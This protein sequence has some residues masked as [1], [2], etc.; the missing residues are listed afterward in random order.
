[1]RVNPLRF[2]AQCPDTWAR[3]HSAKLPDS[4]IFAGLE[5]LHSV[6]KHGAESV[7]FKYPIPTFLLD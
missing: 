7:Q 1:M 2:V 3:V 5:L 4:D 6:Q